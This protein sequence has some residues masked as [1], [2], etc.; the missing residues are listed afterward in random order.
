MLHQ[1]LVR[2]HRGGH[3]TE[4]GVIGRVLLLQHQD[5]PLRHRQLVLNRVLV[6][7]QLFA[8]RPQRGKRFVARLLLIRQRGFK[9]LS[10]STDL[11]LETQHFGLTAG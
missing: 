6:R 3:G 1:H 11:A 7:P 5:R 2:R 8:L 10:L 9:P 4:R